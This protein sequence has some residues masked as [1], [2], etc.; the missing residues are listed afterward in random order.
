MTYEDFIELAENAQP[1]AKPHE[2]EW[3][4]G[5]F[6]DLKDDPCEEEA[7]E[8]LRDYEDRE[9]LDHFLEC[10]EDDDDDDDDDD[11]GETACT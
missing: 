9:Y 2:L 3:L 4:A 7:V 11:D 8:F 5:E 10:W 1:R 6:F